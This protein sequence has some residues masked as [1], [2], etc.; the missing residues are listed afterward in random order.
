MATLGSLV[1]AAVWNKIDGNESVKHIYFETGHEMMSTYLYH[2][3]FFIDDYWEVLLFLCLFMWISIS[4]GSQRFI[5]YC[6][7]WAAATDTYLN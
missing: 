5:E 7:L 2:A 1:I 6:F 4:G 3:G